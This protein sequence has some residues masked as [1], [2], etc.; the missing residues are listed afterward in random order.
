MIPLT[1]WLWFALAL[2]F[3]IAETL[4]AGGLLVALAMAAGLTGLL[5]LLLAFDWQWGLIIFSISSVV[6]ACLWWVFWKNK[7]AGSKPNLINQPLQAM[8]GKTAILTHSIENG[9]GK[10]KM[11][12]TYWFVTGPPLLQGTAVKITGVENNVLRVEPLQLSE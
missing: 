6:F 1:Y 7:M 8:V 3:M 12:D 2:L 9:Q 11:H 5:T 10:I 4:G